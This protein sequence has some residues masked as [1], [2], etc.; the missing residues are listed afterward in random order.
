[1]TPVHAHIENVSRRGFLRGLIAT[2][3]LVVAGEFLPAR[4]GRNSAAITR[5]PVASMP[6]KKPRRLTFSIATLMALIVMPPSRPP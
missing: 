1:M 2:G 4:A 6:R 5:L 3:G